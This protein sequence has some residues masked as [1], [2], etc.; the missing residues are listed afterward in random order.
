MLL[1]KRLH[2]HK[3]L[4]STRD[5]LKTE[6]LKSL[7]ERPRYILTIYVPKVLIKGINMNLY[8]T[9][10]YLTLI[11]KNS[12]YNSGCYNIFMNVSSLSNSLLSDNYF[13]YFCLFI[14]KTVTQHHTLTAV[15]IKKCKSHYQRWFNF[16]KF[17]QY[18]IPTGLNLHS[19]VLSM[20]WQSRL[21]YRTHTKTDTQHLKQ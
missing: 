19:M 9:G 3:V 2:F 10:C 14:N 16:L 21:P 18:L 11:I 7:Q 6:W 12:G 13:N 20:V 15:K 17:E 1:K 4:A 8:Q 5:I